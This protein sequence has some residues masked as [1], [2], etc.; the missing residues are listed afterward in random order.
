LVTNRLCSSIWILHPWLYFIPFFSSIIIVHP[1]TCGKIFLHVM[2]YFMPCVK[3]YS[4]NIP[5]TLAKYSRK[6]SF[7]FIYSHSC[8]HTH[9]LAS[10]TLWVPCTQ[11]LVLKILYIEKY[12][13]TL[14]KKIQIHATILNELI[15]MPN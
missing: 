11:N 10:L 3:E 14:E 7:M 6:N 8:S 5:S 15:V 13:T 12:K 1:C 9:H 2:I 4:S